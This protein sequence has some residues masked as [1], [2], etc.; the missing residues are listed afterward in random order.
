MPGTSV[1]DTL[2]EPC[3]ACPIMSASMKEGRRTPRRPSTCAKGRDVHGDLSGATCRRFRS[4][5]VRSKRQ[6][7]FRRPGPVPYLP[8]T[9]FR[10]ECRDTGSW[11]ENN[12]I[13]SIVLVIEVVRDALHRPGASR[14]IDTP[15]EAIVYECRMFSSV[16]QRFRRWDPPTVTVDLCHER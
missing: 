12:A 1:L 6:R 14:Q 9:T 11:Y 7:P 3:D 16:F 13:S 10:Q 8:T 5:S 15:L 2:R 4:G